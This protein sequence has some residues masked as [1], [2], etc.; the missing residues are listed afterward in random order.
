VR[1]GAGANAEHICACAVLSRLYPREALAQTLRIAAQCR[2]SLDTLRYEYPEEL[3]PAGYTPIGYLRGSREGIANGSARHG[4]RVGNT[5]R[6]RT[7]S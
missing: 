1:H 4:A 7:R 5:D 6:G 3:V 2:F